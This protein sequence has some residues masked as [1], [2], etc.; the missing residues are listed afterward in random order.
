MSNFD[1]FNWQSVEVDDDIITD[2]AGFLG[3]EVLDS[4]QVI[5]ERVGDGWSMKSKKKRKC[6]TNQD[7]SNNMAVSTTFNPSAATATTTTSDNA[8]DKN[9]TKNKNK[10][11]KKKK[12]KKNKNK[13]KLEDAID[14][15]S[16]NSEDEATTTSV[17]PISGYVDQHVIYYNQ[18]NDWSRLGLNLNIC[19]ALLKK[20]FNMPTEIQKA[21]LPKAIRDRRDI[22]A[23]AKTG[24]GKTLAFGLPI[25]QLIMEKKLIAKEK[26]R[27]TKNKLNSNFSSSSSS[28]KKSNFTEEK[29][30]DNNNNISALILTPTRELALQIHKH[31]S[32]IIEILDKTYHHQMLLKKKKKEEDAAKNQSWNKG[33]GGEEEEQQQEEEDVVDYDENADLTITYAPVTITPVVGGIS[34]QKQIR[35]LSKH[36]DIVVA[37]PGRLWTLLAQGNEHLKQLHLIQFFVL[38]EADRMVQKGH[39]QE[40]DNIIQKVINPSNANKNIFEDDDDDIDDLQTLELKRKQLLR[41][42]KR[43]TFLFSATLSIGS[44][45]RQAT[46][47]KTMH[48]KFKKNKRRMIN[49]NNSQNE[50]EQLMERVGL[51]NKP[52]IV[53]LTST[54]NN[55]DKKQNKLKL[56]LQMEHPLLK[57]KSKQQQQQQQQQQQRLAKKNKKD[58]SLPEKLELRRIECVVE[59]KDVYLYHFCS[60]YKGRVLIFANTI[61]VVRRIHEMLKL[62]KINVYPIHAQMQQRQR[63]KNLDRF[64]E[65]NNIVLVATDVASRGIDIPN[66]DYVVHYNVP[67]NV[68]IFIHRSGR[69]A[70]ANKDGVSVLMISPLVHEIQSFKRIAHVLSIDKDR[71]MAE[72][73][74]EMGVI[75]RARTRV[76]LSR[77]IIARDSTQRQAKSKEDWFL[78]QAEAMDMIVDED[79]LASTRSKSRRNTG[80]EK[81]YQHFKMEL[82]NLL[83]QKLF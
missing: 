25:I 1:N 68:E 66:V 45:G 14:V 35:L 30:D 29:D 40:L 62:L 19:N 16:L 5:V 43:Q 9:M 39:Y 64:R 7:K 55:N 22:L 18:Q 50:L 12:R 63:M 77:Q 48:M 69:T 57:K 49:L 75:R 38:D 73:D 72:L 26:R 79:L 67:R 6:N 32:V 20:K 3:L 11:K 61:N 65:S 17:I 28:S 42:T 10:K 81:T 33:G 34:E 52:F 27:K 53:D 2:E 83:Q 74:A 41:L 21:C 24:S 51:R 54:T 4:S 80:E 82:H 71:D 23:A 37:T 47:K 36:P 15:T 78:K 70:R 46:T 8:N 58:I 60:K 59:D 13:R 56:S 31:L 44:L 76:K